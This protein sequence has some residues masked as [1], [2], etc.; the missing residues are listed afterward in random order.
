MDGLSFLRAIA[1]LAFT[2]GLLIGCAYLLKRY[3][4]KFGGFSIPSAKSTTRRM[5]II[6]TISVDVRTRLLLI[7]VD[8]TEH[9]IVIGPNG[10]TFSNHYPTGVMK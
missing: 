2:L 9:L 8:D 3:G 6:E 7:K 4:H 10:A 5:Q 1:A